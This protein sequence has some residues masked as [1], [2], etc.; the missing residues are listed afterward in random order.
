M[1]SFE[2]FSPPLG[3]AQL[4]VIARIKAGDFQEP[5]KTDFQEMLLF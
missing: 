5:K 3:N 2:L 4:R 1:G